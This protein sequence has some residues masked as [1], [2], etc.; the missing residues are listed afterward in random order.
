MMSPFPAMYVCEGMPLYGCVHERMKQWGL[1]HSSQTGD[2]FMYG[3]VCTYVVCMTLLCMFQL[4][5][6]A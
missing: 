6:N 2:L 4:E 3:N 5:D 1:L